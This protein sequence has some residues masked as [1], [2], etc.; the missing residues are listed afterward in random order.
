MSKKTITALS[1]LA[2]SGSAAAQIGPV[3]FIRNQDLIE[4][5]PGRFKIRYDVGPNEAQATLL[6]SQSTDSSTAYGIIV[7]PDQV[8]NKGG[9]TAVHAEGDMNNYAGQV[10]TC[11]GNLASFTGYYG[12]ASLYGATASATPA[13]ISNFGSGNESKALGG[14]FGAGPD[15]NGPGLLLDGIGNYYVGGTMGKLT[16]LFLGGAGGAGGGAVAG[17]IGIDASDAGS[18]VPTF[19]GWFDGD[20]HSTANGSFDGTLGVK[21]GSILLDSQS[22]PGRTYEI[23]CGQRQEIYAHN[24]LVTYGG[25]NIDMR[26]G[27]NNLNMNFFVSTPSGQPEFGVTPSTGETWVGYGGPQSGYTLTVNGSA[28]CSS[29]M[30]SGSSRRWKHDIEEIDDA[31]ELVM[32]MRGVRYV[33]NATGEERVG[34]IAEEIGEVLPEVVLYDDED[35]AIGVEYGQINGVL[36]EA[37][38]QQQAQIDELRAELEALKSER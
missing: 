11:L 5:D 32:A 26:P 1:L 38:Q 29:G 19:A 36:I 17:V 10:G 31:L 18:D 20:L 13:A 3:K 2:L 7:R 27:A 14:F 33:E 9:T 21:G 34:V 15:V 22:Y 12:S 28:W 24:D 16:G 4:Q 25:G 35:Q 6:F 23:T 37:I 30:W 8:T